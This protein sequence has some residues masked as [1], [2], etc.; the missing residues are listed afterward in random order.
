MVTA[1]DAV[2]VLRKGISIFGG[3]GV[4]EDFCSLPRVFRDAAVNELWEGPRNVLLMQVFRD[5]ERAAEFYPPD[6][7]LGDLLT[8]ASEAEIADLGRCARKFSADPPFEKLDADS[9]R[10]AVEWEEFVVD[11]F[12]LYQETALKEVGPAPIIGPGKMS[13]PDLWD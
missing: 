7:F 3:H 6:R 5:L 12:R 9:R 10:R 8:G 4:I 2:D 13:L 1:F 11:V